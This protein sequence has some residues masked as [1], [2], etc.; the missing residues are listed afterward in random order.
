MSVGAAPAWSAD[1]V[2][3]V[4]AE[5]LRQKE[6][7]L[8]TTMTAEV[9][10]KIPDYARPDDHAYRKTV[11]KG[12]RHALRQFLQV[13]E[14]RGSPTDGWREMY[15]EIGAGE[16]REGRSLD[17]VH[18]AIRLCARVAWQSLID[19][20]F[21]DAIPLRDLGPLA[22]AIFTY[23][24]EIADASAEGYARA[25][26]AE[27]GVVEQRRRR[28]VALLTEA[29]PVPSEVVA[30]AA[31]AAGWQLPSRLCVVV[32][33]ASA[34]PVDRPM[35]PPDILADFEQTDPCLI[36]PDPDAGRRASDL[37]GLLAGHRAMV[38]PAV[39]CAEAARSL[40]WATRALDLARQ[41]YIA[42]DGV[43][44]CRDH[45]TTMA[46]FHDEELLD[47]LIERR[48]AP[49]LS[50]PTRHREV[51]ADTLLAWLRVNGVASA[52]AA[53][54]H[55]HPQTARHRLRQLSHVFGATLDDTEARFE[56]QI[57]LRAERAR[58]TR[59]RPRR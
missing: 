59:P 9:M 53:E 43:I 25:K 33:D 38:G 19:D 29:S 58:R 35:L 18:A 27:A 56:L 4:I 3:R 2:R 31:V 49:L 1:R 21:R 54:L 50:S 57:A 8:A 12:V 45:L 5:R 48:L 26:A 40:R 15:A 44:W 20:A 10:S 23:L 13:L 28:L 34:A 42:G 41:G 37:T 39:E 16:V 6:A 46:L 24:D 17:A 47:A 22:E 11:H 14:G 52:V 55:I 32:L 36:V 7:H 30:A 51:L